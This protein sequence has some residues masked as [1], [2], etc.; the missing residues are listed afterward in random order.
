MSGRFQSKPR[1]WH[2]YTQA[3]IQEGNI[4]IH[5]SPDIENY[6]YADNSKARRGENQTYSD[7]CIEL[8]LGIRFLFKLR[9]RQAQGFVMGLLKFMGLD[10]RTPDYSTL[11]RRAK[12]L[13][14]IFRESDPADNLHVAVDASGVGIYTADE[15]NA[16]KH[17]KKS[18]R[19]WLK[20]SILINVK[21]GEVLAN[22]LA[23]SDDSDSSQVAPLLEQLP[24]MIEGFYGDGAY[25]KDKTFDAIKAH[26]S[27]PV[28]I[29]VPPIE[30]LGV[31]EDPNQPLSRRQQHRQY[32][33]QYGRDRWRA[34]TKHGRREKV[35]GTFAR[36][37]NMFGEKLLSQD[38]SV[39][40]TEINIKCKIL[41]QFNKLYTSSFIKE[42]P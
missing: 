41:N 32:I 15:W 39:Q 18:H 7:A 40:Q 8:I 3:K 10:L 21:T 28:D 27:F 29:V 20:L 19:K 2:E 38:K 17:Q 25:D 16:Q 14:V 12:N 6:W 33:D 11:S 9:L 31:P 26:Q 35:E 13:D 5:L 34:K 37:K 22:T 36:F 24:D 42:M 1:Y 4:F 23:T 30:T